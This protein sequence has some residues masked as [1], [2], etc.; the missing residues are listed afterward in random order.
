MPFKINDKI[1]NKHIIHYVPHGINSKVFKP[2]D[3][4]D[5]RLRDR[6]KQLFG[7]SQYNFVVF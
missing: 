1:E 3:I 4:N 5:K 2:L 7:T 6:K